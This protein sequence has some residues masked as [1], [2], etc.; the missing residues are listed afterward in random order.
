MTYC[1]NCGEN[2]I[3]VA[4]F[5]KKCGK[6]IVKEELYSVGFW[7]RFGAY[8]IDLIG[9]FLLAFLLGVIAYLI[10][11]TSLEQVSQTP[12]IFDYIVWVVYSTIFLA[13]WSTTPGKKI[14]GIEVL[15]ENEEKLD[16]ST[17]LKRSLLQPLSLFFFGC[18]Y[19]NMNK[20]PQKQTWHDKK[21]HTIVI[22]KKRSNYVFPIL[23]TI[24]GL[25]I[26]F[27]SRS[28]GTN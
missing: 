6:N 7:I 8:F 2:N 17:S 20:N 9:V 12:F 15:R 10:G 1:T 16:F 19:W 27:W 14:Y 4:S 11:F 21:V 22:G 18:G 13:L 3:E 24:I 23:L 5:C 26:Y 25:I 28:S